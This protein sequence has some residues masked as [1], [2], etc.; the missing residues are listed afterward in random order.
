[1]T[2]YQLVNPYID[3]K[4][5]TV[6]SG[7]TPQDAAIKAW[8][9][10]SQYITNNVPKF[11]FTI[12]RLNDKKLYHYVV[13]ENVKKNT[14]LV[15]Y[16][17]SELNLNLTDTQIQNF[18]KQSEKMRH[19][20]NNNEND[21]A[22][23]QEGGHYCKRHK[24]HNCRHAVGDEDDDSSSSSD[25]DIYRQVQAMK[26]RQMPQPVVYW[27]YTPGLYN[28]E[29]LYIPTFVVPLTPYIELDLSSAVFKWA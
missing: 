13:K 14:R 23:D 6:F 26:Y 28:F 19:G 11:A 27:W 21:D 16:A 7:N 3:G 12:E 2:N 25:S 22:D 8:D 9:S 4:F 1:M 20:K 18:R 5:N 24:R 10:V 29:S 17:I 15:D